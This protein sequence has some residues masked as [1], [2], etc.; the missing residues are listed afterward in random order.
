MKGVNCWQGQPRGRFWGYV[1]DP[2]EH[3]QP[4]LGL[5][6]DFTRR[7]PPERNDEFFQPAT[8][9]TPKVPVIWSGSPGMAYVF[10]RKWYD[11]H[12]RPW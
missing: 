9:P 11:R 6:S 5:S 7:I 4:N 10:A 1:T 12:T 2:N 8:G 3:P